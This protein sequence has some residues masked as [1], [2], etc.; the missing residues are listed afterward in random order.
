MKPRN[1]FAG[2]GRSGHDVSPAVLERVLRGIEVC[3]REGLPLPTSG[4]IAQRIGR[5]EAYVADAFAVL[6][7]AGFVAAI[8]NRAGRAGRRRVVTLHDGSRTA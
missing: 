7:A 1:V 5:S 3:A 2:F 6:L 4:T 8:G